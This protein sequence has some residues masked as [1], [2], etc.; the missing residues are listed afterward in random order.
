MSPST[1]RANRIETA[2]GIFILLCLAAV[3]FA[4]IG[5]GLSHRLPAASSAQATQSDS[6]ASQ[7]SSIAAPA[8]FR[9]ASRAETYTAERLYEKI[10]GKA[11]MYLEAGFRLLHCQRFVSEKDESIW[12]EVFV[13]D[14]G[15]PTNAFGVF[16]QQKRSGVTE[17]DITPFAYKTTDG[18]YLAAGQKYI[19][20]HGSVA[21]EEIS[22]AMVAVA[23][24][25]A[26]S[27]TADSGLASAIAIFPKAGQI[28]GSAALYPVDAF[29]CSLLTNVY[30]MQYRLGGESV[31]A[32]VSPRESIEAAG[33]LAG[34]YARFVAANGGKAVAVKDAGFPK[35]AFELYGTIE[36]VFSRGSIVAGVHA[37][38]N[39]AAAEELAKKLWEALPDE[40]TPLPSAPVEIEQQ[41]EYYND[42]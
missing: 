10:D 11:D 35:Q 5:T 42:E 2:T 32:F 30:S 14:M 13:Y 24:S 25:L 26:G 4:V 9:H 33:K 31:M 27:G 18:V 21:S 41:G 17:L 22:A 8:G 38:E 1:G 40:A 20:I 37:A 6:S 3:A 7:E 19:E 34:E 29:G 16:G 23:A 28:A 12:F 15:S 36:V 39:A